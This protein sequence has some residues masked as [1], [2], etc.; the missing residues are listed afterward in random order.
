M[1]EL[2][3]IAQAIGELRQS[4]SDN[5]E[6]RAQITTA[7]RDLAYEIR[8]LRTETD[9]K[10]GGIGSRLGEVER[11]HEQLINRGWGVI[12]GVGLVA[13]STGA[14]LKTLAAKFF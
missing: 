4:L 11:K 9:S 14:S 2:D 8:A 12:M 3:P 7:L 6:Q 13:G 1:S 10:L 5:K